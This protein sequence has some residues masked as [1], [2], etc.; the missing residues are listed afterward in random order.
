MVVLAEES[1][2]SG[3]QDRLGALRAAPPPEQR[4]VR[5]EILVGVLLL[6]V[7]IVMVLTLRGSRAEQL[8]T[9]PAQVQAESPDASGEQILLAD[10][11]LVALA[12]EAGE[13]PPNLA[14]GDTVMV[15]F[16]S[17]DD[18][19]VETRSLESEPTV[20][21]VQGPADGGLHWI[22]V[23]RAKKSLPKAVISA[24]DVSLSIVSGEER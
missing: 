22:V 16:R 15:T 2:R 18:I 11:A 23:V 6:A 1:T 13:F 5:I 3:A 9:P 17:D 12:L 8:V 10:E 7:G 4:K 14:P 19:A 24:R 20:V 21:S